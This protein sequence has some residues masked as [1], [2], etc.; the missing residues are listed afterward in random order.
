M[1]DKDKQSKINIIKKKI[2]DEAKKVLY[3]R[4]IDNNCPLIKYGSEKCVREIINRINGFIDVDFEN[5]YQDKDITINSI[6]SSINKIAYNRGLVEPNKKKTV[7]K[8]APKKKYY[9]LSSAQRRMW[10]PYK[11][12]P[13]SSLYNFNYIY[14]INGKPDIAVLKKSINELVIRHAS[15]RTYFFETNVSVVQAVQ[16]ARNINVGK[17]FKTYDLTTNSGAQRRKEKAEAIIKTLA[18]T[19]FKLEDYPLVRVVLIKRKQNN[20]LFL[21]LMHHIII[22]QVSM[23]ILIREMSQIYNAYVNGQKIDLP[24]PVIDYKDFAI[25]E[26]SSE[27]IKRMQKHE[28]YWLKRMNLPLP[29][30]NIPTDMPRSSIST[31][32]GDSEYI[33]LNQEIN[34]RIR[35]FCRKHDITAFTFLLSVFF[36]LLHR[37]T[38]QEDIIVGI[39]MANR[40]HPELENIVGVF[41]NILPLRVNLSHNTKFID[42]LYQT[43]QAVIGAMANE[44]YPFDKLIEKLDLDRDMIQP[45]VFSCAFQYNPKTEKTPRFTGF[46]LI[47]HPQ[48]NETAK[49]DFRV[50]SRETHDNRIVVHLEYAAELFTPRTIQNYLRYYSELVKDILRQPEKEITE[51]NLLPVKQVET[52]IYKFNDTKRKYPDDKTLH[53]LFADQVKKTPQ[54]NAL[55]FG[56]KKLTYQQLN[57]KANQLAH[58]LRK[59]YRIKPDTPVALRLDRSPDMI[60]AILAV[61]KAGGCYVPID[62]DYPAERIKYMLEDCGAKMVITTKNRKPNTLPASRHSNNRYTGQGPKD[63]YRILDIDDRSLYSNY[64]KTNPK[65]VNKSRDLAYIIYTS[66]STGRPKGVMIEHRSVVNYLSYFINKYHI[67]R[68]DKILQIVSFSFDPSVRDI[69]VTLTTGA[70]LVLASYFDSKDPDALSRAIDQEKIT[71]IISIIPGFLEYLIESKINHDYLWKNL[72]HIFTCGEQLYSDTYHKVKSEL[73][74]KCLITNQYGPTECT[75]VATNFTPVDKADSKG[76]II[77]VG[78]PIQNTQVYILDND[79]NL[80]P[81]GIPGEIHISGDGLARGYINDRNRT[82]QSF[83]AHPLI[84]NKRIYKS[85]DLGRLRSDGNIELLG[86]LDEQIKIKGKRIEPAEIAAIMKKLHYIEDCEIVKYKESIAV[87]YTSAKIKPPRSE[88]IKNYLRQKLPAYMIPAYYVRLNKIPLTPNGKL[89]RQTLPVPTEKQLIKQKYEPPQGITEEKLAQIWQ[90][91]LN[92]R[93]ISRHDNFFNLGGNSL[94]AIQVLTRT[95]R[96]FSLAISLKDIFENPTLAAIGKKVEDGIM[97]NIVK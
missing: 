32:S 64:P 13:G 50:R 51:L 89:D 12:E 53:Q 92:V 75:M 21:L 38:G 77:P 87:Y 25:W 5:D 1:S 91:V 57:E 58:Y 49:F 41:F 82:C 80:L 28:R 94:I 15:L 46:R 31:H 63:K 69:F 37:L 74:P 93:R 43:N 4:Q 67:N 40:Q 10:L 9:P 42:L 72:N 20:Y 96:E 26:Q 54:I 23:D 34:Q 81:P 76:S 55:V 6:I 2:E 66:G 59:E 60:I 22:D 73:S 7:I 71:K 11:L 95:N 30:L 14:E 16:P 79:M 27:N 3:V 44:A 47:P 90:D 17:I 62:P 18:R 56:G 39:P 68:R 84:K 97:G 86:R 48:Y 52:L 29:I 36:A 78:A 85:G 33:L 19:P 65:N 61:L 70:A 24:Q 8:P 88:N 45:P 83:L 35:D